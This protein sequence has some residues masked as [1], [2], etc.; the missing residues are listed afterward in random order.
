MRRYFC[1]STIWCISGKTKA[2]SV[3]QFSGVW[4]VQNREAFIAM[5]PKRNTGR[6]RNIKRSKSIRT[7]KK[8]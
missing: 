3:D 4:G 6:Q 2:E 7:K 8:Q 1:V 5:R